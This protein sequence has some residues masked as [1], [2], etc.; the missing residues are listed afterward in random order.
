MK[1]LLRGKAFSLIESLPSDDASYEAAIDLLDREFLDSDLIIHQIIRKIRYHSAP[2]ELKDIEEFV[3]FHRFRLVE[4]SK[5]NL[6]FQGSETAACILLSDIVRDKLPR[7]FLVELS[8][9]CKSA[10]PFIPQLFEYSPN[11]FK[12]LSCKNEPKSVKPKQASLSF[13]NSG[14][15]ISQKSN[16]KIAN[17]RMLLILIGCASFA[18]GLHI[19]LVS[20]RS[21]N[22][23]MPE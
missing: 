4:L 9:H 21:I 22:T 3:S 19:L 10:Y 17:L 23:M 1:T 7:F 5:F 11:L 20:A 14:A 2:T 18:L 12:I 16:P 6:D 8:R 13:S 15:S